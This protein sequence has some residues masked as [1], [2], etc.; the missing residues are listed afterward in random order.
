MIAKPVV[1][2]F[3]VVEFEAVKLLKGDEAFERKPLLKAMVVEVEFSPVPR[4]VNGKAK[5]RAAGNEVRQS[6]EIQRIVVEAYCEE[7]SVEEAFEKV[8]SAVQAFAL[9]RLSPIVRAVPPLY[10][11]EKVRVPFVAVRSARLEPR[12]IPL[13]V[14]FWSWLLPI[15]VVETT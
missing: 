11:P 1:V 7:K 2:A 15:V 5:V 3:V 9:F 14:E 12:A 4:V 6:P 8:W 10:V 13:I